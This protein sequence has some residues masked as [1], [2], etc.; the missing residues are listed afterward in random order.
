MVTL[1]SWETLFILLTI[2]KINPLIIITQFR[3]STFL[4]GLAIFSVT[5]GSL[6]IFN[7]SHYFDEKYI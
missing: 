2:Q 5:I 4:I 7:N 6:A 1:I 3:C